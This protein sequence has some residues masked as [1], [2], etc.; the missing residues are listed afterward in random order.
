MKQ[1]TNTQEICFQGHTKI[2]LT[3]IY[4]YYYYHYHYHYHYHY[5]SFCITNS[6]FYEYF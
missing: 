2:A 5:Y 4:P 3:L 6:Q 1:L